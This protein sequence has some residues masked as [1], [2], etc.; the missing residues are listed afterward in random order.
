MYEIC[1][2]VLAEYLLISNVEF[3]NESASGSKDCNP[4][5]VQ[6]CNVI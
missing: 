4:Q 5:L 2:S 3:F 1:N 6:G